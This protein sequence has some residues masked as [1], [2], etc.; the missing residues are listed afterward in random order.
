MSEWISVKDRLPEVR[1]IVLAYDA[2]TNDINF[3]FRE[4]GSG[5]FVDCNSDYYLNTITHWMPLPK[6]PKETNDEQN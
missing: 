5:N 2:Q 1:R 4:R 3:A 6:P